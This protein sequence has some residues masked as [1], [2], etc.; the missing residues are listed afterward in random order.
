MNILL[1]CLRDVLNFKN[2]IALSS[3]LPSRSSCLRGS[4][5]KDIGELRGCDHCLGV[6]ELR[7]CDRFWDFEG[8][9][10]SLSLCP[11]CLEWFVK[12]GCLGSWRGCDRSFSVSLWFVKKRMFGKLRGCDSEALRRNR[13]WGG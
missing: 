9:A 5:K 8:S 10:I 12:K 4:L 6:G 3:L 1:Y 7:G 11:L 2:A 13:F